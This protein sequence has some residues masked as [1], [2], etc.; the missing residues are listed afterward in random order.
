MWSCLGRQAWIS[1]SIIAGVVLQ[2]AD[3]GH[4]PQAFEIPQDVTAVRGVAIEYLLVLRA[5]RGG[6][7]QQVPRHPNLADVMEKGAHAQG[8]QGLPFQ[9]EARP[10]QEGQNGHVDGVVG[11]RLVVVLAGHQTQQS[12]AIVQHDFDRRRQEHTSFVDVQRLAASGLRLQVLRH[13]VPGVI[14][15]DRLDLDRHIGGWGVAGRSHCDV[16]HARGPQHRLGATGGAD[17]CDRCSDHADE[18]VHLGC[19][20]AA[21]QRKHADAALQARGQQGGVAQALF[22]QHLVLEEEGVAVDLEGH[23]VAI[24][25]QQIHDLHQVVHRAFDDGMLRGIHHAVLAG[26]R[27]VPQQRGSDG[28]LPRWIH[29]EYRSAGSATATCSNSRAALRAWRATWRSRRR[30]LNGEDRPRSAG[31]ES[32]APACTNRSMMRMRR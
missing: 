18:R 12:P 6:T 3:G 20:D 24:A 16:P 28:G 26:G 32:L 1:R 15:A 19:S 30:S 5:Q 27:Q 7:V 29:V 11:T 13:G 23:D 10:D 31:S 9:A 2:R 8:H 21:L 17:G 25:Q 22:R 4:A 14:R